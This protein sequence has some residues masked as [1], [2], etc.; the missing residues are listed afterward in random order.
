MAVPQL[1]LAEPTGT[2]SGAGMDTPIAPKIMDKSRQILLADRVEERAVPFVESD[3]PDHAGDRGNGPDRE[4]H[5]DRF[6]AFDVSQR[7]RE[8]GQVA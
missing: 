7:A 1:K 8:N 4:D 5:Q 6:R 2:G 3:L